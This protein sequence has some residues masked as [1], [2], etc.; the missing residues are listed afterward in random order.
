MRETNCNCQ[1]TGLELL[2]LASGV[3]GNDIDVGP[4]RHPRGPTIHLILTGLKG[5]IHVNTRPRHALETSRQD[6]ATR[7]QHARRT[8][9]NFQHGRGRGDGHSQVQQ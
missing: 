3:L 2:L 7:R 9:V 5:H 1:Q 4:G 6:P 8:A